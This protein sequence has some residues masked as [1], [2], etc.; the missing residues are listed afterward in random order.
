YAFLAADSV[1]PFPCC[2]VVKQW[3]AFIKKHTGTVLFEVWRSI[4]GTAYK[5]AGSNEFVA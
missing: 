4:S 1:Y 5:L 3:R 2:G